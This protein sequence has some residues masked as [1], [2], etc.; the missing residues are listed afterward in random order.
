MERWL[1]FVRTFSR[2]DAVSRALRR[3]RRT[4]HTFSES[5]SLAFFW[6][7]NLNLIGILGNELSTMA[8]ETMLTSLLRSPNGRAQSRLE[9]ILI[10]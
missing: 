8:N 10:P 4:F 9:G 2:S 5:F 7:A 3:M 1:S 6:R